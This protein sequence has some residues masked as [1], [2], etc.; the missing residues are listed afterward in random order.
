M[1]PTGIHFHAVTWLATLAV[2]GSLW[3][4]FSYI[5]FG[6]WIG[7]KIAPPSWNDPGKST[8]GSN[9]PKSLVSLK[10]VHGTYLVNG[11]QGDF[12]PT[13]VSPLAVTAGVVVQPYEDHP[14]VRTMLLTAAG[15]LVL[16]TTFAVEQWARMRFHITILASLMV[17]AV[18]AIAFSLYLPY[19][20]SLTSFVVRLPM[21]LA[22]GAC[23]L[24]WLMMTRSI[25]RRISAIN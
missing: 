12:W 16:C 1:R 5:G 3:Y 18:S 19:E 15:L 11:R 25:A 17:T 23:P 9:G 7:P 10:A 4:Q 20:G 24:A 8:P 14:F 21:F 6:Q 22:F 2:V 13:P